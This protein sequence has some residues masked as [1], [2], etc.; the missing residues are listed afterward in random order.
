MSHKWEQ[1]AEIQ[2]VHRKFTFMLSCR[3][4][5]KQNGRE[6][7]QQDSVTKRT[8]LSVRNKFTLALRSFVL[9]SC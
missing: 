7:M 9:L 6:L 1:S 4:A 8:K 3:Y 5:G 2:T